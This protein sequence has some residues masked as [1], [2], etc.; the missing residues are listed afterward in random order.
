MAADKPS[1]GLNIV[2]PAQRADLLRVDSV[3]VRFGGIT[4]LDKVSF[5]VAAGHI[6]GLIGPNGAG[7]TTLFDCLSRLYSFNE[8]KIFFE[9]QPLV[10]T[11]AHR[12]ASLGS[13]GF[14]AGLIAAGGTLGILL[15]PSITMSLFAVAVAAEQSLGRLFLAGIGPGV[16]LVALFSG[17][18]VLRYRKE[19]AAAKTAFEAGGKALMLAG[20]LVVAGL[21]QRRQQDD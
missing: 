1:Q 14:A 12:I 4:A 20:L 11:P 3:S 18:A 13:P 2:L 19:Y 6:V 5:S 10:A 7:K 15:P 17:Y 8:G 9:G 21:A 16:L